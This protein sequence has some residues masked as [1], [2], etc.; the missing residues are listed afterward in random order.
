MKNNMTNIAT[1]M[2]PRRAPVYADH[3]DFRDEVTPP[4]SPA[5]KRW[6]WVGMIV[7]AIIALAAVVVPRYLYPPVPEAH[8]VGQVIKEMT[9]E[10]GSL[11]DT[12]S[13]A[14]KVNN[15]VRLERG[16]LSLKG[17]YSARVSSGSAYLQEP[18][19]AT[20]D[21]FLS[22]YIQLMELPT[23]S[24]VRLVHL[25]SGK[26]TV[27]N[28]ML[29]DGRLRL[30]IDSKSVGADSDPLAPGQLYRIGVHQRAG[31]GSSSLLEAF[32]ASGDAE[33]A[34]PF[35]ATVAGA[36]PEGADRVRIGMT[37]SVGVDALID[38]VRLNA[39]QMP[40]PSGAK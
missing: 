10:S 18:L 14:K 34:A 16:D 33:F 22:F 21:V 32:L 31:G 28:L 12:S 24:A 15:G 5:P 4:Y 38:D 13:G 7:V 9:F 3:V 17:L 40:G 35:A 27:G 1:P 39:D 37:T 20:G 23:T 30:R 36:W 29:R 2:G 11:T 6:I 26:E 8:S 25:T 19:P